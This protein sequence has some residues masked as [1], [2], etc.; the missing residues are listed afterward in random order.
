MH[1]PITRISFNQQVARRFTKEQF[2]AR[3]ATRFPDADLPAYADAMGL[4]SEPV[5]EQAP[6]PLPAPEDQPAKD[7]TQ[8][9]P[10][11]NKPPKKGGSK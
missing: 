8:A 9:L 5:A 4:I 6:A 2:I 11:S 10:S 3:Y 7:T 1:K